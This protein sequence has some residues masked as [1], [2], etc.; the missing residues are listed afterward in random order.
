M[1]SRHAVRETR[2]LQR[3]GDRVPQDDGSRSSLRDSAFLALVVAASSAPYVARLGFYSDDWAFLGSLNSFGNFS[4]AGRSAAFDFQQ[5]IWQRP[6]QAVYSWLLF[7]F[8]HLDPTGYHVTN[9]VVVAAMVV[10]LYLAL[11]ELGL[12]RVVA[13]CV[14]AV[15]ALLPNYSTD[16]F[17]FAAFG[18][19]LTMAAYFLSLFANLR[20]IR[21]PLS[22]R[23]RWKA[24]ALLA[25]AIGGLGYEVVLPLFVINVVGLWLLSRRP[26]PS[27]STAPPAGARLALFLGSDVAALAGVVLYKAVAAAQTGV[28]AN[29][30]RYVLW[31]T[32]GSVVTNLGT[33]GI[34]LPRV[35]WWAA[36]SSS[37]PA[38]VASVGVGVATLA[39]VLRASRNSEVSMFG[40]GWWVKLA[41][42]GI[43]GL[44]AG[45]SIFLVTARILFTSTGINNRVSIAGAVGSAVCLVAGI[46]LVARLAGRR[47]AWRAP[48]LAV[49]V[50]AVCFTGSLANGALADRWIVAW[51][52]QRAVLA[53]L[54]SRLPPP[55]PGSTVILDG[56]CPYV[57]PAVVFESN[58]DLAGALEIVYRDPTI[59]A[60]VTTANLR[61]GRTGITTTLY[62]DHVAQYRYGRSL[63]LYDAA[64]ATTRSLTDERTAQAF[65][66]RAD[67]RCPPGAAGTGVPIFDLDRRFNELE[68]RFFWR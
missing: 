32:A 66:G 31:L 61:I 21:S 6:T 7:R 18:Y 60:D 29:Y 40:Y 37:W 5:H 14:A 15:Y 43:A 13:L 58:W 24:I 45:Y 3:V 4:N 33:Y 52:I 26:P 28:P 8:F 68:L 64:T 63:I 16:R 54:R 44:F 39:Y 25:L 49:L 42:A 2:P 12:A 56:V 55:P 47:A 9:T 51:H 57:G 46:G 53:E 48:I 1:P 36:R 11:R 50:A 34:D 38:I 59:R 27:G 35:A 23:W 20:G 17:W 62:G 30:P 65:I 10:L 19:P 41:F 22:A 67:G